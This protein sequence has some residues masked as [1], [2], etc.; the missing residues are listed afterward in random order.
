MYSDQITLLAK[1]VNEIA[2]GRFNFTLLPGEV[3]VPCSEH[4]DA[5][6]TG[7]R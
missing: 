5:L 7:T 6:A 3:A 4:L 1:Y 2:P